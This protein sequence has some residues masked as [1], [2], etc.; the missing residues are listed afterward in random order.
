MGQKA[1]FVRCTNHILK[2][3]IQDVIKFSPFMNLTTNDKRYCNLVLS[4]KPANTVLHGNFAGRLSEAV[5][6]RISDVVES[7]PEET[8]PL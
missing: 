6:S 3:K 5:P 2:A 1:T 8:L 4:G 7:D